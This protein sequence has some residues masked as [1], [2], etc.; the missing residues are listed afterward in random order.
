MNMDAGLEKI[1]PRN[2]SNSIIFVLIIVIIILGFLFLQANG[3]IKMSGKDVQN[4]GS[5]NKETALADPGEKLTV[6]NIIKMTD[7]LFWP[8]VIITTLGI[9]LIVYYALVE[10]RDR[11]RAQHL[12]RT[13][14]EFSDLQGIMRVMKISGKNRA[15]RLMLQMMTTFKKTRQAEPISHDVNLFL[16][17]ERNS[18]STFTRVMGFLSESAGA[19]GLLGTVWGIFLTFHAGKLDGPTILQGMSISLVT[20]LVGLIIS[21]LLN[22]GATYVFTL[23]NG[24]LSL[25][26]TR[27]EELRQVLLYLENKSEPDEGATLAEKTSQFA[28]PT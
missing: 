2:K 17:A 11:S 25:L 5:N 15:S 13:R 4:N 26:N 9:L 6:W 27:A 28:W 16:A 23:F 8:F 18:F 7:W 14:I 3:T 1:Q 22:M 21:L 24:Q 20:T 10:H 12:L 19:L